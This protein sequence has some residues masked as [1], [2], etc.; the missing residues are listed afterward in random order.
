MKTSSIDREL[1]RAGDYLR[2]GQPDQARVLYGAVLARFPGNLRAQNALAALD[3]I[4]P[5]PL[6]P[7][8][9][10]SLAQRYERGDFAQVA[11]EAT[12]LTRRH[13]ADAKLWLL[14][15]STERARGDLTQAERAFR[16]AAQLAPSPLAHRLHGQALR[17]LNRRD[18]AIASFRTAL[19]DKPED[20]ELLNLLGMALKDGGQS[21]EAIDVLQ[22]AI[23]VAPDV[24]ILHNNLGLALR[25][26]GRIDAAIACYRQALS[27]D[28]QL[29][30][31]LCNLGNALQDRG[32]LEQA[33]EAYRQAV[34]IAPHN[35]EVLNNIGT[36]LKENGQPA[37][38]IAHLREATR[39][40]P[41]DP[42]IHY[43][44][45]T[46]LADAGQD[47]A[48]A[49]AFAAALR[50]RP[51]YGLALGQSLRRR[52]QQCDWSAFADFARHRATLGTPENPIDP[53]AAMPFADGPEWQLRNARAYAKRTYRAQATPLAFHDSRPGRL[54]IGY[55][56]A[57]MRE[58]AVMYLMSGLLREHDRQRYE[59]FVFSYGPPGASALRDQAMRDVEHF[60]DVHAMDD[61][62]VIDLARGHR[63]DIAIDCNGYTQH[64]RLRLFASRLA[65]VQVSYLGYPGTLGTQFIDYIVA[66]PVLIPP[67]EQHLYTE[68]VLTLPGSYQP[69]D[70]RHPIAKAATSRRDVGLPERGFVFACF[71]Q[72]YKIGPREFDI[73][74]RLLAR[75]PGSILWLLAASPEA[76][77]N[78]S[79]EASARGI[80]PA[81]LVFAPRLP[82]DAHL[83]RHRHAD[84]FVDTFAYNAH[85][86]AS[87]ALW[88]GLPLVTRRGR[89]FSAR[90]GASLLRAVGLPEL[91]T[92]TDAAYEALILALATDPPRLASLRAKLAAQRL[93]APLFDT[94]RYTR[95]FEAALETAYIQSA[96]KAG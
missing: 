60:I 30:P 5:T 14:L 15:G 25:A 11:G 49:D 46:A 18:E 81:R 64:S 42:R 85:T 95:T 92:E 55:F 50:H 57:D 56:S 66:D 80:D 20:A 48:A 10:A 53:F 84:L 35:A 6:D 79:R 26:G 39:H 87:D 45:G 4:A 34:A 12:E 3:R 67:G 63:L 89:Q 36:V 91:V 72:A 33:T 61:R 2:N 76:K 28:P 44:L 8:T 17:D 77:A 52:A 21:S 23:A 70:A 58:H 19:H 86:T 83:A 62:A 29:F 27:L 73:W 16:T 74:M 47:T 69:T 75:V 93:T 96:R 7:A 54:R 13:P 94:V 78:L 43:N 38:A 90:V 88:A 24:P 82:H 71:N 59:I 41:D 1:R 32:H 51:D 37:E 40:A 68:Q 22:T 9:F 65:P 31:A